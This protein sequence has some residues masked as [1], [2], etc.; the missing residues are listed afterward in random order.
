MSLTAHD[1]VLEHDRSRVVTRLFLPG[2]DPASSEART[3]SIVER[4]LALSADELAATAQQAVAE[5]SSHHGDVPATL[6]AHA[7]A[8]VDGRADGTTLSRDQQLVVGSVFT[9][10]FA[11]EGAALCNPSTVVHPSQEGLGADELRVAVSLRCIGEGHISSIGFADAVIGADSTWTFGD[12]AQPLLRP[13]VA[14]GQWTRSHFAHVVADGDGAGMGDIAHAVLAAL[15]ERFHHGDMEIAIAGLPYTLA[16]R[17]SSVGPLQ[18]LREICL[19]AYSATFPPAS[20]LSARTLMPVTP[21]EDRGVEDARFVRFTDEDGVVTYRATY[22]AYDGRNI[23]PRLLTS[24]DLAEFAFHRLSGTGA[25][26]KGMALFPRLIGG[27]HLALTRVGGE[28]ISLAS[29]EDGLVWTDLGAVCAPREPWELIQLGNCGSPIE[30]P[31]GWLVLTHGVGPLRTYA[32]GAV[33]LDLDDPSRVI[34][35]TR[36]P[37][38]RPEGE[39]VKGY[40]PRVVYSCGGIVHRDTLWIPVGVGDSR[41]RVFSISLGD[42]SSALEQEPATA[43]RVA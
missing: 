24:P 27:R 34:R 26:N 29:S 5:F 11:V 40:V 12:R 43:T 32:L 3:E 42:L 9:A 1:A 15:P 35:R 19:S 20:P 36:T 39:M 13:R 6:I 17:P 8:V 10:D 30:T 21:E 33:L 18:R 41:I 14:E 31:E 28:E 38:L 7:E 22:T 2:E 37:L 16:M 4:V 25:H 23:A